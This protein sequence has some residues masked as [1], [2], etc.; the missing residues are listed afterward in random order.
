[1]KVSHFVKLIGFVVALS[2]LPLH[3]TYASC[4]C[5]EEGAAY[6]RDQEDINNANPDRE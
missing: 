1:M 5:S 6:N 3:A 4:G 2:L